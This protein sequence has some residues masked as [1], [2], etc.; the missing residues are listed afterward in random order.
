[1]VRAEEPFWGVG[2]SLLLDL[3][4]VAKGKIEYLK[5][6]EKLIPPFPRGLCA[7]STCEF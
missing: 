3:L 6:V 2:E 7:S 4:S 1:L 5:V